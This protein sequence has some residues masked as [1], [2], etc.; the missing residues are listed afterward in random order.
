MRTDPDIL[1]TKN[2]S[3]EQ[4]ILDPK[5]ELARLK[6]HRDIQELKL[7]LLHEICP[8]STGT[9]EIDSLL[10][11][12]GQ[13]SEREFAAMEEHPRV[14]AEI[15]A[16]IKQLREVIPGIRSHQERND[17]MGYPDGLTD[18]DIPLV[19][20]IIA[21]ADT[22]D[23][24]TTDRPYRKSLTEEEAGEEIRRCT[25][26]QFD[27]TAALAFLRAHESGEIKRVMEGSWS[28][29]DPERRK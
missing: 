19:A 1:Q 18:G 27:E 23:A 13:L 20:R 29:S 22:Y 3:Y 12:K 2:S 4:Q 16:H 17:G 24:M 5:F 6:K 9:F 25:G 14:G 21:V 11:K 15:M 10:K 26:R 8:I 7:G 28:V